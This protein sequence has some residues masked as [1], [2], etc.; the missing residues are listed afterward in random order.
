MIDPK[1]DGIDHINVYSK[2]ATELGRW[3]SN[4]AYSPV[5]IKDHGTFNS[6]E[7]YWYWLSCGDEKLRDL[8]GWRAKE[9]GRSIGAPDWVAGDVF[10]SKICDAISIKL[11]AYPEKI[12]HY[13]GLP[14]KHYY[15]YG[16]KAVEPKDGKWIIEH[17]GRCLSEIR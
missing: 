15:V 8:Y 4:F 14:L 7:G 11:S 1:L 6:I 16:G 17:I 3:L 12:K 9:Y 5:I 10:K 2:G 13:N